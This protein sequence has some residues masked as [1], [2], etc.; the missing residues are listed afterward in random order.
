MYEAFYGL[1]EKPFKILPDAAYFYM[2]RGHEDAYTHLEYAISENKGFFVITGDIGSGKT[3]LINYL[4]DRIG[5]DV[6]L[7]LINNT[8]VSPTQLLKLICQDFELDVRGLDKA[9]M[10]D[11]LQA[12]LIQKYAEKKRVIL[13]I[14]EAQNL[15]T[16]SM[17]EL[18]MLSN[19]EAE[20]D[21]LIQMIL[22]GQPG[23]IPKI[24]QLS[25]LA[26]RVTVHNHLGP[27]SKEEIGKY[28]CYRLKNAGSKKADIFATEAIDAISDYSRGIPRLINILC[29]AA[30]V[31]GFAEGL[32][33]IDRE[34]VLSVIESRDAGIFLQNGVAAQSADSSKPHNGGDRSGVLNRRL[35]FLEEKLNEFK[36]V[37]DKLVHGSDGGRE[38]RDPRD[39]MLLEMLRLLKNSYRAPP[40]APNPDAGELQRARELYFAAEPPGNE[41]LE[42][43]PDPAPGFDAVVIP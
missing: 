13:I 1:K 38:E 25:Q 12:F 23:L 33:R 39:E 40:Q 21:H 20:K 26:Q 31:Y 22:V 32:K 29:D 17:E 30:L 9:E 8:N 36:Q 34:T 4:L 42:T 15:P 11:L 19:L 10:V 35:S 18:R 5:G 2:S 7:G 28:I 3:T 16:K 24:R 6:Q 37:V 14:D 43:A 27:L 41:V